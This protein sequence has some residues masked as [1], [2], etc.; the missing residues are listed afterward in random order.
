MICIEKLLFEL[1]MQVAR[2]EL[3]KSGLTEEEVDASFEFEYDFGSWY[4]DDA[5]H[6]PDGAN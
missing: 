2:Q 6:G 5:I 4:D 3:I 1:E